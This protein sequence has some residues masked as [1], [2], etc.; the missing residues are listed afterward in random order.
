MPELLTVFPDAKAALPVTN[1]ANGF[2]GGHRSGVGSDGRVCH[3]TR[4]PIGEEGTRARS[5]RFATSF[6]Q[7]NNRFHEVSCGVKSTAEP[8]SSG[9]RRQDLYRDSAAV[10]EISASEGSG[11]RAG[12]NR[13]LRQVAAR[14]F[15][16]PVRVDG[17][18]IRPAKGLPMPLVILQKRSRKA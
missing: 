14:R 2:E 11:M 16:G 10:V 9:S 12:K 7:G 13:S 18:S 6:A 4:R 1:Q 3:L 15:E 8:K 5:S 17:P